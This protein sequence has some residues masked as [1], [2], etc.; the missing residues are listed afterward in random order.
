[1]QPVIVEVNLC[2]SLDK[3]WQAITEA[4]QMRQWYFPMMR[5][6][7][8]QVGFEAEFNVP[9]GDKNYLH[10]WRITEVVSRQKLS[11]SWKYGGYAGDSLVSFELSPDGYETRLRLTHE[12]I[13]SFQR[14]NPE[15]VTNSDFSRESCTNGWNF[16]L[17]K[18]LK[19]FV[20]KET[21]RTS[22]INPNL[23]KK[24]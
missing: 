24:F 8:A 21:T 9:A 3:V 16:L 20:E 18:R 10:L 22:A 15:L 5:S 13:E 14:E 17:G 11:Y 19:K 6:F 12:G 2:A 1:M 4:N 7:Q 23:P